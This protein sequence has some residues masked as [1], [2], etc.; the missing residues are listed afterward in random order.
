VLSIVV[1]MVLSVHQ[2]VTLWYNIV[3]NRRTIMRFSQNSSAKTLVFRE[4]KMLQ[5]FEG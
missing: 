5:K 1:G 3:K 2:S 4:V